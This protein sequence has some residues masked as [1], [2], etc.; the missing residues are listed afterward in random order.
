MNNNVQEESFLEVLEELIQTFSSEKIND[1]KEEKDFSIQF[2]IDLD[3]RSKHLNANMDEK[4][5]QKKDNKLKRSFYT[6]MQKLEKTSFDYEIIP[7]DKITECVFENTPEEILFSF[8]ADLRKRGE[9]YFNEGNCINTAN[10]DDAKKKFYKILRHID[11]AI[12][13]KT[14]FTTLKIKEMD[15]LKKDYLQLNESYSRLKEE[16]EAQY[17]GLLTQF[18]SILGIF[19]AI[20]MG[21]F[22]SIQ[23]FTSLFNNAHKLSIG[24]ILIISSIGCSGVILILFF[25]LNGIAKMTGLSLSSNTN[26]N[27]IREKHPT[28]VITHFILIL[29]LLIGSALILSNTH[30]KWAWQG[31]FFLMP[32]LW[33]WFGLTFHF[34]I[35]SFKE[36]TT[37]K[38]EDG[39]KTTF[40]YPRDKNKKEAGL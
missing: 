19:A 39:T 13:Q 15:E 2:I 37:G 27:K 10:L 25:L 3:N 5:K 23:G 16:A 30:I 8:T 28:L 29:L 6:F 7:Y 14:N 35:W 32:A 40:Y 31:I 38:S 1:S 18:I 34:K 20:L 9:Q 33:L 4:G 24:E 11:L 36:K 21:A 26:S 17:K 22:G 12:V